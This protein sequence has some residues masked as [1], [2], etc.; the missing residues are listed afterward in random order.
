[1]RHMYSIVDGRF[2]DSRKNG[3]HDER[4]PRTE[5]PL[6]LGSGGTRGEQCGKTPTYG[7]TERHRETLHLP[8]H[9]A[10]PDMHLGRVAARRVDP[11]VENGRL[12][13]DGGQHG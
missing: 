7:R 12:L 1:M 5:R 10:Y 11:S 2:Y 8:A 4:E 3:I 13:D 9:A 6:G